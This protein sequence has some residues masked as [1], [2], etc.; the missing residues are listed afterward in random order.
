MRISFQPPIVHYIYMRA[1][2]CVCVHLLEP[3]KMWHGLRQKR[4]YP[5]LQ[6]SQSNI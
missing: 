3:G 5:P 1:R 6:L 2:V 4:W